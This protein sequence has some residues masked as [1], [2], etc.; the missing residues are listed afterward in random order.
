M[1]L[2]TI[3]GLSPRAISPP[4]GIVGSQETHADAALDARK[5]I[6]TENGRQFEIQRLKENRKTA[7]ANLTKQI[8]VIWPLL[9]DLED[10]KQV[11]IEAI[12]LDRLFVKMQEVHD[13]YLNALDDESEINTHDEDV[14]RINDYLHEAK[15]LRSGLHDTSSMK[16][17]S[18]RHS[19][20]S[21]IPQGL[22]IPRKQA[23][24]S[25]MIVTQQARGLLPRKFHVISS[26]HS[27]L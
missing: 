10:E 25:Q 22:D 14:Q 5:R 3:R 18:S 12:R 6:P 24:L 26:I 1:E 4:T 27:V 11:R 19:K 23:E 16:Y 2:E 20:G 13:M 7:L 9:S 21:Q 17:K 8:K 15:K